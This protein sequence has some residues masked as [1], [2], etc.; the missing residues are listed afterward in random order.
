MAGGQ[1]AI[2]RRTWG[3]LL[4][5]AVATACG[6]QPALLRQIDKLAIVNTIQRRLLES[7]DAEKSAVLAL[8]DE[9]S[10]QFAEQSKRSDAEIEEL[11]ARLAAMIEEDGRPDE[12]E[13]LAAFAA[14]WTALKDVDE[15][16]LEL[17]V[18]NTNLKAARLAARDGSA[19]L[20][21]F[22]T[23]VDAMTTTSSDAAAVRSLAGAATAVARIQ[24][25]LFVHIPESSDAEMTS[26]EARIRALS[27]TVDAALRGAATPTVS[28]AA[29]DA[30]A[31][32]VD[33]QRITAEVI[34]LSRLNTN[35]ISFDVSTHEKR[36]AT[37]ACLDALGELRDAIQGGPNPTR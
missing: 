31:A 25:L 3:A 35:V 34:R 27:D 1:R 10:R 20:D 24:A 28:S 14:K 6:R 17:A 2:R 16:L 30:A 32:W 18:A 5:L 8:T 12:R 7:V 22:I 19:A 26:V 33:Y 11:K 23:A 9:E 21:R 13:K 4:V 36:A 37:R 29:S 15:R